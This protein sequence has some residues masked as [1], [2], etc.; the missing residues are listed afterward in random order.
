MKRW[1]AALATLLLALASADAL[2]ADALA[3]REKASAAKC[4]DCHGEDGLA[5]SSGYPHLAGQHAGYLLKQLRDLRSGA[6]KSPF[7]D[8]VAAKLDERDLPDIAAYFAALPANRNAPV[9]ADSAARKLYLEGDGTRAIAACAGCHGADGNG[10][11][12]GAFPA[13]GGQQMFYLREQ[14]TNWH[15]GLRNN[16]PER[17]MS[18]ATEALTEREIDALARYISGL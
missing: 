15:L 2:S 8:I 9:A 7:M 12:G 10:T 5:T 14:L 6:R 17:V 13:I 3:G 11:A 1:N 4:F 18:R 16:S